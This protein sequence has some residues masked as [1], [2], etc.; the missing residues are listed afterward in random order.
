MYKYRIWKLGSLEH[1]IAPTQ[2]AAKK[3]ADIILNADH[4][5]KV[6]KE[7]LDDGETLNI[8]WGPDLEVQ[9]VKYGDDI[10]E[11]IVEEIKDEGDKV[12]FVARKVKQKGKDDE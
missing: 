11:C 12:I 2:A 10:E 5:I 8:I 3:L 1:K 6:T 4:T 7:G 9:D